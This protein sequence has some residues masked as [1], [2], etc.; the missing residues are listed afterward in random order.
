[1]INYYLVRDQLNSWLC[2]T[3][4]LFFVHLLTFCAFGWLILYI[5]CQAEDEDSSWG[6]LMMWTFLS[7][8]CILMTGFGLV[9]IVLIWSHSVYW[10]LYSY[11]GTTMSCSDFKVECVSM[12]IC[13][14]RNFPWP[15]SLALLNRKLTSC[16]FLKCSIQHERWDESQSCKSKEPFELWE[17]LDH[18]S[19]PRLGDSDGL[20][21]WT[22]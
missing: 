2:C 22:N 4:L 6:L 15:P 14:G 8:S 1:M 17:A 11:S 20:Q 3:F 16:S 7:N 12:T 18:Q 5:W 9:A 19:Q 10:A 21:D 13:C